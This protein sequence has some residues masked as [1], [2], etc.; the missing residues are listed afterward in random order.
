[1]YK[2]NILFLFLFFFCSIVLLSQ[3]KTIPNSFLIK[4]NKSKLS[5]TFITDAVLSANLETY[6]LKTERL[7]IKFK[8][9]FKLLLLSAKE[10][11]ESGVNLNTAIYNE[12]LPKGYT[13]P[14][15]TVLDSGFLT[16]EVFTNSK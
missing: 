12:K 15:F 5:E 13:F 10:L 16:A 4:N 2:K 14:L 3:Q 8:N 7:E 11:K 1:M 9:G 6:R